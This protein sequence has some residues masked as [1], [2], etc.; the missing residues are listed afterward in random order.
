MS[1]PRIYS[2]EGNI[3]S[4]KTTIIEN[5]QKTF[6]NNPRVIFIREPVDIWQTIKDTDGETIL[7]KFY[8][9]PA[10]YAFTFQVMAYSTRL[11]MLREV[12]RQNP[13]C[14]TIIC[15]R[16]LDADKHIFEKMLYNDGMIDEVS[17][18]IY[19]RFYGEFQDEFQ[20]AG[21]VYIDADA[22]VCKSRIEKRARVGEETVAL[23]YLEKC[24]QYHESWLSN[25]ELNAPVLKIKTNED[26]TYDLTC[27]NDKGLVWMMQ[28]V[29]FLS[30]SYQNNLSPVESL[31]E[32]CGR[33]IERFEEFY[34]PN[35]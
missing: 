24:Q 23:D 30:L 13:N 12:I 22:V 10:K 5:L 15:E 4:G 27:P 2:I 25:K 9:D 7:S 16:S 8:K 31:D 28:I 1:L 21:I 18:Q 35:I 19:Q 17:H 6:E 14:E 32:A 34:N 11:S 20:L 3:G 33:Q 26:V 29:E